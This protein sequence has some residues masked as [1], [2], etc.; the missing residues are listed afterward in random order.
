MTKLSSIPTQFI[1]S[2][3]HVQSATVDNTTYFD[4]VY[5]ILLQEASCTLNW[6]FLTF[7]LIFKWKKSSLNKY[8][9]TEVSLIIQSKTIHIQGHNRMMGF[10]FTNSK[11]SLLL[12]IYTIYHTSI[13]LHLFGHQ[14]WK[15][16][17]QCV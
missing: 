16:Y 13:C 3:L 11:I 6:C 1:W 2:N 14:M 9:R 15:Y 4:C 7:L 12:I 10:D 17:K 5:K 8:P